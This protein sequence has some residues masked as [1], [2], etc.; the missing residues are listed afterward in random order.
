MK[1]FTSVFCDIDEV[2]N[3]INEQGLSISVEELAEDFRIPKSL[4]REARKKSRLGKIE[5]PENL[6]AREKMIFNQ[7][8]E[9]DSH[10]P[11]EP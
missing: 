9:W 1:K 10:Y 6:V 3:F 4:A 11:D 2:V 5:H 8:E 7:I